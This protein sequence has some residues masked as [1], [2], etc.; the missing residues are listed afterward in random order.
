MSIIRTKRR[1]NYTVIDNRVYEDGL[2]SFRAMGLLSYLLSKPDNWSICVPA[3]I[4]V[5]EDTAQKSGRDAVYAAIDELIAVGFITRSK[6]ASGEMDYFIFDEPQPAT[7]ITR[8]AGKACSGK[9]VIGKSRNTEKACS[10]LP[11]LRVSR[12]TAYPDVLISTDSST[13]TEKDKQVLSCADADAP[14]APASGLTLLPDKKPK[15]AK[16]KPPEPNPANTATW[17]AYRAA[18]MQ[19]YGVE[20]LRNAKVNGQVASFVKLVGNDKAPHIAAFYVAH[21]NHWYRTKGHDFGTLLANAQAVA[22]DWQ[23]NTRTTS[24]EAR[25]SEKTASNMQNAAALIAKYQ[26]QGA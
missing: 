7:E 15:S 4:R 22:T 10:G 26:A 14:D 1:A 12:N 2:L 23:R 21:P 24:V 25:Q 8:N 16:S 5:T 13:S 20:P 18:Y 11:V 3:L 9:P 19:A 6:R 17:Q